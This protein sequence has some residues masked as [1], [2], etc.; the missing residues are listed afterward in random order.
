MLDNLPCGN[1]LAGQAGSMSA[2]LN[3]SGLGSA[4]LASI[5]AAAAGSAA[6][7]N[8]DA[9]PQA[10]SCTT[11]GGDGCIHAGHRASV[12]SLRI[13]GLMSVLSSL[14]PIGFDYLVKLDSYSRTV[15]AEAG[16][17]NAN[18][19]VASTGTLQYWNGASYTSV[20]VAS[21]ASVDI[22][23]AS[24]TVSSGLIDTTLSLTGT[25]RTGATTATACA[26]P[27]ADAMAEAESPFIGDIRYTVVVDG[28][29]VTD[30]L[31]HVDL[32][33]VTAHAEYTPSA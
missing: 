21:G 27:C 30:L 2:Q 14:A 17:G 8:F 25:I 22:P 4:V 12:G 9:S 10:S 19:S 1:A 3:L 29:T 33:T 31:I 7:T 23:L 13:G 26:S 11:T 16:V 6:D 18:P 5:G 20:A 32:G 24:V 15:T 28:T